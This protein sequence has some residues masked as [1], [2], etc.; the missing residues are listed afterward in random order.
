MT[1]LKGIS[2]NNS[3][4]YDKGVIN[5]SLI[6]CDTHSRWH[7]PILVLLQNSEQFVK[8]YFCY[9]YNKKLNSQ[10]HRGQL[11][12]LERERKRRRNPEVRCM[13]VGCHRGSWAIHDERQRSSWKI[14]INI[15]RL[16]YVIRACR[17]S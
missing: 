14:K 1:R 8:M 15:S 11:G 2:W 12:C 6:S 10:G 13:S 7:I 17:T 5:H 9:W 3:G 16:I 4:T